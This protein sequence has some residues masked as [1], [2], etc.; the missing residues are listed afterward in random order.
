MTSR[1]IQVAVS[2]THLVRVDPLLH[3]AGVTMPENLNLAIV[4]SRH[5]G[6]I[7]A[8]GTTPLGFHVRP[9][10][11]AHRRGVFVQ[12]E[13]SLCRREAVSESIAVVAEPGPVIRLRALATGRLIGKAPVPP[14]ENRTADPKRPRW[15]LPNQGGERGQSK[16]EHGQTA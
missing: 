7:V 3:S 9:N 11:Y 13:Q 2:A 14:S 5:I 12:H 1:E 10:A 15:T 4:D 6:R 16:R 8:S